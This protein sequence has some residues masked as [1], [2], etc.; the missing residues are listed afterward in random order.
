MTLHG[1][2][3]V[4]EDVPRAFAALVFEEAPQSLALSGG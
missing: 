1:E 3:R 2:L 4:V